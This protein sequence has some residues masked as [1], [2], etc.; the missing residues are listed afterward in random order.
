M[1]HP[2]QLTWA[3]AAEPVW[4]Y[5][6]PLSTAGIESTRAGTWRGEHAS[7][8][9]QLDN[10]GWAWP[11]DT[12]DHTV[13]EAVGRGLRGAEL[14]RAIADRSSREV[15]F[16]TMAE[17]LPSPDNRI[18]PDFEQRDAIG[19]PRPRITFR[20]DDYTRRAFEHGRRIHRE[21]CA[22]L[23]S[24]EVHHGD[25]VMSSGHVIGHLS[26]GPRSGAVGGEPRP[27]RARS[28]EPVSA[29][30]RRVSNLSGVEPDVDDRGAGA[31]S[32]RPDP[33]CSDRLTRLVHASDDHDAA[34]AKRLLGSPTPSM[35][36]RR[37]LMRIGQGNDGL[38]P[39]ADSGTHHQVHDEIDANAV[40]ETRQD[41]R[42]REQ[43]ECTGSRR[44]TRPR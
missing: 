23:K 8:R 5:R 16:A 21:V 1:D 27:A 37:P 7:F 29:G 41:R 9:I 42:A 17:Q 32:R 3:L 14:D 44:Q 12:P 13:R 39:A 24:T 4:P 22:A 18:V 15:G 40:D 10:R 6:G 30:Q 35:W 36:I 26:H 31:A 2:S 38:P 43:R 25:D 19:L 34:R 20:I 28:R 33:A 11:M